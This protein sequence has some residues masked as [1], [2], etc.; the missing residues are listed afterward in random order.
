MVQEI[1]NIFVHPHVGEP[2]RVFDHRV[3]VADR[4]IGSSFP[5]HV[6][7]TTAGN[8][9]NGAAALPESERYFNVFAAPDVHADVVLAHCL[10][11]LPVDGKKS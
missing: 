3:I 10:E 9:L 5:K 6:T 2:Q 4:S 11:V 8:N 1:L 7:D